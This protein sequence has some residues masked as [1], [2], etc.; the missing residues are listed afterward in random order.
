MNLKTFKRRLWQDYFY[1]EL[2]AIIFALISHKRLGV[3]GPL[4]VLSVP[5][6]AH[7]GSKKIFADRFSNYI[8]QSLLTQTCNR[9]YEVCTAGEHPEYVC[10]E[11]YSL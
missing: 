11:I 8:L 6:I 7:R 9:N 4:F 1:L 3:N 5:F 2:N 10:K